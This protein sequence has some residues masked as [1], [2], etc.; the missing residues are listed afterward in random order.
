MSNPIQ[1]L[2]ADDSALA[3]LFLKQALSHDPAIGTVITATNGREAIQLTTRYHPDIVLMDVEMPEMDGYEAVQWLMAH[4]PLPILVITALDKQAVSLRM[5]G[6]GA[7]DVTQKPHG[8]DTTAYAQQL[9]QQ[10][11]KIVWRRRDRNSLPVDQSARSVILPTLPRFDVI[12]IASSTGGPSAL[13]TLLQQVSV[14]LPWPIVI[15]Q[16]ITNGFGAGLAH[17]LNTQTILTV[18]VARNY[19]HIAPGH[20]YIAPDNYH[21]EID[22]DVVRLRQDSFVNNVRPSA[23]ILFASLAESYREKV[24]ALVLTGMGEDGLEGSR[25]I[26]EKGGFVVAQAP[27][28]CVVYGMPHAVVQA[29]VANITL[30]LA[31]MA[32]MI[33]DAARRKGSYAG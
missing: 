32:T 16:H 14:L 33:D 2:I 4:H 1:V 18:Q 9:K 8:G 3:R 29:Q 5:L 10:I 6:A 25:R 7:I 17:W 30:T 26:R 28:E 20:V 31:Q 11:K 24:L 23:D 21:M 19:E 22:S 15:V 12:G 27:Q 13:K